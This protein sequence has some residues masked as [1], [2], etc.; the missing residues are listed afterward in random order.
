[1]KFEL[2]GGKILKYPKLLVEKELE[3]K[4]LYEGN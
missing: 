2:Q 1:M 4:C 3:V